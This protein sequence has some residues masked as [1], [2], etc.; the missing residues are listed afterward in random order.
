MKA[1]AISLTFALLAGPAFAA[2]TDEEMLYHWGECAAVGAIYELAMADSGAD[3]RIR[4]SV[5]AYHA[6]EA[7]MEAHTNALA[8]ALGKDR[9]DAVQAKL[10]ESFDSD[11]AL[12]AD[13]EDRDGFMIATWGETMDRCLREAATLPAAAPPKT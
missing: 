11:I 2:E 4:V 5:D 12:W 6:F 10:L 7:R 3:P 13:T 9:A 8:D 1:L